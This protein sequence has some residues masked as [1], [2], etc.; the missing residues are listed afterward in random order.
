[1]LRRRF[2][3]LCK[4]CRTELKSGTTVCPVCKTPVPR[5]SPG[6]EYTNGVKQSLKSLVDNYG[7]DILNDTT[8]FIS[9]LGLLRPLRNLNRILRASPK[10]SLPHKI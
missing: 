1:M 9:F 6:F 4:Q 5:S 2:F 8:K 3:M 7:T 10:P